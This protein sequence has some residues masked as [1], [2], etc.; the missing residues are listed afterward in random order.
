MG[1]K[2]FFTEERTKITNIWIQNAQVYRLPSVFR[3]LKSVALMTGYIGQA[4]ECPHGRPRVRLKWTSQRLGSCTIV[5][6]NL[7]VLLPQCQCWHREFHFCC[8]GKDPSTQGSSENL[9]NW[10][11]M[12]AQECCEFDKNNAYTGKLNEIKNENFFNV[13]FILHALFVMV[14]HW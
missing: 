1:V 11:R 5:D 2:Y 9:V 12:W 10:S 13:M 7:W 14:T 3:T 8:I 6:L 4:K